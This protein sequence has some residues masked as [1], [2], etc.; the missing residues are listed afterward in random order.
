MERSDSFFDYDLIESMVLA[1]NQEEKNTEES[2]PL[3]KISSDESERLKRVR[4]SEDQKRLA[5]KAWYEEV[6]VMKEELR[7]RSCRRQLFDEMIFK[8][9]QIEPYK[10]VCPI[11]FCK[12][13]EIKNLSCGDYYCVSCLDLLLKNFVHERRVL[14][15]ELLCPVC[16]K[17]LC[18]QDIAKY[19]PEE[20][21]NLESLRK[22]VRNHRL[23]NMGLAQDCPW[24][25]GGHAIISMNESIMTC[26]V[27]LGTFCCKCRD[28]M[29]PN[30]ECNSKIYQNGFEEFLAKQKWKRCP[31][32]GIPIE[33][34]GGCNTVACFSQDCHGSTNMCY[35]CGMLL[36]KNS[37]S[38]FSLGT[39]SICNTLAGI[40]NT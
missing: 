31:R 13:I 10:I 15:E 5:R 1:L 38:H 7:Q 35:L 26:N 12:K 8:D 24:K 40:S 9:E 18:E 21:A 37:N 30:A 4:E 23:V 36:T 19:V 34:T 11:C 20:F 22:S 25:C 28:L 32:C 17:R 29:H 3:L 33:K 2:K 16:E 39:T 27:C 14:P 6:L